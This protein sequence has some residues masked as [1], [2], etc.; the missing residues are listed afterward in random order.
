VS[1]W[2]I[3]WPIYRLRLIIRRLALVTA[4]MAYLLRA[5]FNG[6]GHT[7]GLLLALPQGLAGFCRTATASFSGEFFS[8]D[9]PQLP[10]PQWRLLAG[11]SL[12]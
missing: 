7:A 9:L 2:A 6:L 5:I 1:D 11:L 8:V 4:P 10:R 3:E 12:C